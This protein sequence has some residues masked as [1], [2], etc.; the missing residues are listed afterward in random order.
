MSEFSNE[1]RQRKL[2]KGPKDARSRRTISIEADAATGKT[3]NVLVED[4]KYTGAN[5]GLQ[6][7]ENKH[8]NF[9]GTQKAIPFDTLEQAIE[10]AEKEFKRSVEHEYF[11]PLA[12]GTD[13]PF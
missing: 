9:T 4:S 10:F 2:T 3:F 6:S 13:Y 11:E 7:H 8:S 12:V 1:V 5:Y